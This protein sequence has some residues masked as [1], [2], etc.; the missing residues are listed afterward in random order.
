MLKV[1]RDFFSSDR[2][3]QLE[4]AV[5]LERQTRLAVVE[6]LGRV[7]KEWLRERSQNE[8]LLKKIA[9]LDVKQPREKSGRFAK[10]A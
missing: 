7:R 6:E 5:K 3:W 2:V 8:Q 4:Y 10:T 9:A 1:I